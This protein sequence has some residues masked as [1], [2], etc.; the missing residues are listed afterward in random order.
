MLRVS[1]L[2]ASGSPSPTSSH[3]SQLQNPPWLS[4]S[5]TQGKPPL[6][7][8][9]LRPQTNPQSFQQRSH[10]PHQLHHST[11][12][13]PQ[14]QSNNSSQQSPQPSASSQAQE[15][16]SQ[17]FPPPRSITHQMQM[18]KGP[19]I[20]AQR[21]PHGTTLSGASQ[22]GALSKPAA[23]DPEESSNRILTKR[24]IQE[25]VN[26]VKMPFLFSVFIH[27]ELIHSY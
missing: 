16:F 18:S 15:H 10:I 4:S 27:L 3:S 8:Q 17:Q 19:G 6:P 9:S 1:S 25:L 21:P 13:T 20:R 14:Q 26:Q 22:P 23:A 7:T 12:T 11:P 5:A 24:S 2:G